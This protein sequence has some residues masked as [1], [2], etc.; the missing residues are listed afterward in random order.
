[1]HLR[2]GKRLCGSGSMIRKY[3]ILT[4]LISWLLAYALIAPKLL[5][6]QPIPKLDGILMFPLM[7]LGPSVTSILLTR[8]TAGKEGI[9]ALF[10]KMKFT[11]FPAK[12][13]AVLLIPPVTILVV[14]S[15]MNKWISHDYAPGLFL[16][17]ILF[18]IPAGLLE[19][20]GWMGF[21]FPQLRKKFSGIVSA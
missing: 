14:L 13:Y 7:L 17:G 8:V 20:I 3:F 19:E 5:Q 11:G 15:A 9:R 1:M 10:R 2:A 12:W 21:A 18:G 16:I 4:F 6:H